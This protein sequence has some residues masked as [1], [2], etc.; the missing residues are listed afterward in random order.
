MLRQLLVG[1]LLLPLQLLLLGL[2]TLCELLRLLRTTLGP[3][4]DPAETSSIRN[5]RCSIIML[6]WNGQHLLRESLPAL[7]KALS[8]TGQHHEVIVV[9]N[10]SS[11]GSADWLREH[12]PHFRLLLLK[13]NLGFGEGNNRG[14]EE[15]S[16]DIVLLLN[17][18]MIV[19][20]DFLPPLLDAFSDPQVF[21]VS[22]QILFPK[23]RRREE[24]GNTQGYFRWGYFHLSHEPIRPFHYRRKYLPVL[25]AGGGS[26]AFHRRRFL[27]LGGFSDLFSPCYMEDTDLSY[28]AWRRSWKVLL[29]AESKVLHKHRSSSSRRFSDRQIDTLIEEHRLWYLWKNFSLRLLLP[30]LLLLPFHLGTQGLSVGSYLRS[31]RR[32]R[33]VIAARIA[34]PRRAISERNLFRWL[35]HPLEFLNHF[36]PERCLPSRFPLRILVVSA[37]LPHLGY[38]GG[39]GRVFQLL[40]RVS[41]KHR[42]SVIS[43]VESEGEAGRKAQLDPH[44]E[45]VETVLR[46]SFSPVSLFPYEPFEEFNSP[47][48]RAKLEEML[49]EEDFHLVHFEWTQM[50]QYADLLPQLP[51]LLTEIEV[52]YAAHY[53]RLRIESNPLRRIGQIYKSLQTFYRELELCRKADRVVCVTDS[54]RDF[55]RGYLENQKLSV[56]NTG[57]DTECFTVDG[58][59][60][61]DADMILYVGAFRHEPNVDAMHYFCSEIFPRILQTR[62]QTHLF[63][64]GSSPPESIRRLST[65]GRITVTGYVQDIRDFYHRSRVVVV[66]LRTGVGIRGKIL[67]GWATGR[68]MV[69]TSLA[70]LGLRTIHG[71]NILIA[72]TAE[73]FSNWVVALL[74]NP[75]FCQ[76]LGRAG[77]QTAV[78]HYDWSLLGEEMVH[79]YESLYRLEGA[80]GAGDTRQV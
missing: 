79:L 40:H 62:P 29:A 60:G 47:R 36:E 38:H 7:E 51:K 27:Q 8:F 35:Q 31:L 43:F 3:R 58:L 56:V 1:W 22:S 68:A 75:D 64:V 19:R 72:D 25:W 53:T 71:E 33:E 9:D 45:R 66:P 17:N 44:C 2:L 46:S 59:R 55:L 42:V 18:D 41:K 23:D 78:Q 52:N 12:Y 50:A 34:E 77:R 61:G 14:V 13:E 37:Y 80:G 26:S 63:I 16:H 39:A 48:F 67:E 49:T 30:H 5:T 28:R 10:G 65:P 76:R 4:S 24:T 6:N 69:A 11:D 54:D 57:V 15:A 74:R 20:E 70:C 73:E 32:F 21:A